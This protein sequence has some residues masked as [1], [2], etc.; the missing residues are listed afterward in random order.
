MLETEA[1]TGKKFCSQAKVGLP[2]ARGARLALPVQFA[3]GF[4]IPT[5]SDSPEGPRKVSGG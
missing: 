2:N 4:S 5:R 3:S 1:L